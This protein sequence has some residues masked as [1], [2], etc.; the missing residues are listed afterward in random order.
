MALPISLADAQRLLQAQSFDLVILDQNL[1]DGSGIELLPLIEQQQP[2]LPVILFS[3]RDFEPDITGR[4]AVTLVK[5]RNSNTELR[6]TVVR[7]LDQAA[8]LS[9]SNM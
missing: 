4:V 3:V 2:P 5:S 9:S 7:L 6:N 8:V 1:P